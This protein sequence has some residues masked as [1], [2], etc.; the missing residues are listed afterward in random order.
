MTPC[1]V[2]LQPP[3]HPTYQLPGEEE[4]N[5]TV[6]GMSQ[7]D[8]S[9]SQGTGHGSQAE[10]RRDFHTPWG[11]LIAVSASHLYMHCQ[12]SAVSYAT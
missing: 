5:P 6:T 7:E 2:P 3:L 4:K 9:S 11:Q 1:L 10:A 12:R 8:E